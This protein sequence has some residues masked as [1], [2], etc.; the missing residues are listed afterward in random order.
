MFIIFAVIYTTGGVAFLLYGSG[1]PRKWA[2]FKSKQTKQSRE[3]EPL[4]T[5]SHQAENSS[6]AKTIDTK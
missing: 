3:I 2:T 4:T 1:N 5:M 6:T